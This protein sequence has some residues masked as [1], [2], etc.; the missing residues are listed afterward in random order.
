MGIAL[1]SPSKIDGRNAARLS[2]QVVL[3]ARSR[4]EVESGGM[5]SESA[6]MG[7]LAGD[8]QMA[9]RLLLDHDTY[10]Q[11]IPDREIHTRHRGAE[12]AIHLERF[13]LPQRA[14]SH[15]S[16]CVTA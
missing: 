16:S 6:S 10:S 15:R 1:S 11:T 4:A 12:E 8:R 5:N 3:V 13:G 14:S 7:R 9:R 2:Q